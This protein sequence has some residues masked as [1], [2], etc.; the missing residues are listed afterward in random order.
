MKVK[1]YG[2]VG[3][4]QVV[5]INYRHRLFQQTFFGINELSV[6]VWTKA[7]F[8]V[9]MM[10]FVT[11]NQD[12]QSTRQTTPCEYVLTGPTLYILQTLAFDLRVCTHSEDTEYH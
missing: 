5:C 11:L 12:W 8:L 3:F 7:D 2:M 1:L 4:P 9:K 10:S 6:K